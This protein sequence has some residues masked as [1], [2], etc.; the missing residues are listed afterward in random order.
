MEYDSPA[1]AIVFEH[2]GSIGP[3]RASG[4]EMLVQDLGPVAFAPFLMPGSKFPRDCVTFV[5][6]ES[7]PGPPV[8][9]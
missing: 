5:H 1:S 4:L 9:W 6:D 7:D 8:D 2:K 3:N